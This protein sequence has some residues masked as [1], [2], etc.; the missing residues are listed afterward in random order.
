MPFHQKTCGLIDP[1][2]SVG[3]YSGFEFDHYVEGS[4]D[5]N[6]CNGGKFCI[7]STSNI[8][9]SRWYLTENERETYRVVDLEGRRAVV[10]VGYIDES[11]NPELMREARAV[12]DS[13]VFGSG[14]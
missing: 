14:K 11:I 6:T 4:V 2:A 8:G 9:C 13:V 3:D 5:C 10:A 7:H 1:A 12:F